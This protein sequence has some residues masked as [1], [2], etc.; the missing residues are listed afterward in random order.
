MTPDNLFNGDQP[1]YTPRT[2]KLAGTVLYVLYS[3][4]I[5]GNGVLNLLKCV[6]G[7]GGGWDFWEL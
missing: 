7:R 2:G 1:F 6:P 4:Y 5:P 3:W